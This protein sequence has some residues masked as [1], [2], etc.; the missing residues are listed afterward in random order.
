[1]K[2]LEHFLWQPLG[3]IAVFALAACGEEPTPVQ[4]IRELKLVAKDGA[5]NDSFG[6]SVGISKDTAIVGAVWDDDMG[7]DSGSAYVFV[8][9]DD[10][11]WSQQAKLLAPDGKENDAFGFSVDISEDT[12]IVGATNAS[13]NGVAM[14]A[15]YV[16]VRTGSEW[17]LEAKLLPSVG[18]TDDQFGFAV[19]L[20]G[21]IAIIGAPADDEIAMDAGAAY[22]FK[23]SGTSW[24]EQAKLVPAPGGMAGYFGA[25]VA[26]SASS[27]LVGAWDDGSGKNPGIAFVHTTDGAS[28]ISQATLQANDIADGDTFGYSVALSGDAAIVGAIGHDASGTDGG[29]AYLF[30]R[31]KDQW[32]QED[33][34]LPADAT[35]KDAF[36]SSVAIWDDLATVG[37]YW[38][39]DRGDYSGSAYTFS[40]TNGHWI[41]QGKHAPLD[42]VAGQKF[43]CAASLDGDLAIVGAYGDNDFGDESGSAYVFSVL[44]S[45]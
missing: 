9:G 41:E 22:T 21:E 39:D 6:A 13:E 7:T 20:D 27:T 29:A 32:S 12:A 38:D 1:M 14:G 33:K 10:G 23:R 17:K 45:P 26:I 11:T 37:A 18:A 5:A 44:D 19:A 8:R 43:G 15:A 24:I 25:A 3:I 16:F 34:L 28:W 4:P 31:S 42:G 40:K 36:G 30:V 2:R 35:P